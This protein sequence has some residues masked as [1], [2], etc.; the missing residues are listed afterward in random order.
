MY[1]LVLEETKQK[2]RA[3]QYAIVWMIVRGAMLGP[4]Q[5]VILHMLDIGPTAQ[6]LKEVKMEL[7]DAA[8]LFSKVCFIKAHFDCSPRA[9]KYS[10]PA[11]L[12]SVGS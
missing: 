11:L 12:N 7:I 6:A 2:D 1:Y 5:P 9:P 8:I 3:I 4:D 10:G